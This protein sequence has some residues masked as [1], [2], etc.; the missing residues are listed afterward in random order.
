M[1]PRRI[2]WL[3]LVVV[4]AVSLFVG[5]TDGVAQTPAERVRTLSTEFACPTCDGQ[6]VADSNAPVAANIVREIRRQV[7]DGRTDTEIEAF[8]VDRYGAAVVLTPPASGVDGLIWVIPVVALVISLAGLTV[9]F[10]RWSKRS[11]IDLVAD[12]RA[13]VEEYLDGV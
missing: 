10:R 6:S 12:D 11:T 1:S 5:R 2:S 4:L 7:D 9:V 8:L 13:L 3:V